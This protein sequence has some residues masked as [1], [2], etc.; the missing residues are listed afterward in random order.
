MRMIKSKAINLQ[1][2]KYDDFDF[3]QRIYTDSDL[4]QHVGKT[5]DQHLAKKSFQLLLDKMQ[6]ADP[7]IILYLI[8]NNK[9]GD[10]IGL[11]GL[12]WNQAHANYVEVGVIIIQKYQRNSYAH[13]AKSLIIQHAFNCLNVNR[14]IAECKYKN[15]AAN[16][17]NKKL[18]FSQIKTYLS[19]KNNKLTVQWQID[20][21]SED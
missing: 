12:R 9:T 14:I 3:Y 4:M 5:L 15:V 18:G 11:I 10:K 20:N 21:K 16:K 2:F 19:K 6:R 8:R 17:A 1:K 13:K 7:S